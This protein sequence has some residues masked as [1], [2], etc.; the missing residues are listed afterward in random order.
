MCVAGLTMEK[1][2]RSLIELMVLKPPS[3]L[4]QPLLTVAKSM[5]ERGLA[6]QS[7]E[8][9]FPTAA[10]LVRAGYMVH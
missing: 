7:S 6:M 10:G 5:R 1:H 2:E 4:P 9:W 8:Q 3:V